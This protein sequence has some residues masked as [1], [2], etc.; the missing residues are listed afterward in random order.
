MI[1]WLWSHR[2]RPAFGSQQWCRSWGKRVVS[3]RTLLS[4]HRR[5]AALRRRGSVVGNRVFISPADIQGELKRLSIGDATFIGRVQIQVLADV[6]IGKAVCINDGARLLSASHSTRDPAWKMISKPIII[7]DHAWI[8]TGAMILPGVTVGRGA[9]VGA[10]A[11][12][13]RDVPA[14]AVMTGNPAQETGARRP[15]DLSYE[16]VTS[17]ALFNAWLS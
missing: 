15:F 7:E 16:P 14:F 12:V 2:S 9:V 8:A 4:V 1:G 10:G 17:V 3:F 13:R 11:V 5:V 6:Q